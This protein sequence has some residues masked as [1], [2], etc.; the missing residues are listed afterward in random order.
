[1]YLTRELPG[2]A[3][4]W[5]LSAAGPLIRVNLK[6]LDS[7]PPIAREINT[8]FTPQI[9][10]RGYAAQMLPSDQTRALPPLRLT[11]LWQ[12]TQPVTAN[13][14]VSARLLDSAG[15]VAAVVDGVPVH[16][17]YPTS[18]WRPGEY[19]LDVYDLRLPPDAPSGNYTPLIILYDPVNN[20]AE[21]GRVTL[22]PINISP[23]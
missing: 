5:S 16:F 23:Q 18:F 21:M 22:P 1:V 3:E 11:L 4:R 17:A 12:A 20:A 15:E 9:T 19:I 6:P 7:P 2:A 13:L 8:A 14:K 10:L